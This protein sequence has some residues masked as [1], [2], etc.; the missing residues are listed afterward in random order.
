MNQ[1]L[2]ETKGSSGSTIDLSALFAKAFGK[3]A[4]KGPSEVTVELRVNKSTLGEIKL[5]SNKNGVIDRAETEAL[6]LLLKEALKEH[7]FVRFSDKLA[8]GKKTTFS[9]L[10]ELDI[11]AYYNSTNLSLDLEIPSELRKP[12]VLSMLSKKKASVREENKVKAHEISSFANLYSNVGF[13]SANTS[14]TDLKMKLEGSVNIGGK[15]FE[16][17]VDYRN[18][19]FEL[20]RTKLTYDKPDKLQ[21]FTMGNISTGS[22]NFQENLELDGIRISK[23]FFMDPELQIRPK[24]NEAFV[25]ESDSE[26]EVYINNRLMQRYYLKEGVYALE[27]I[28]LYD[29][30]NNIRVRI[31]DEF[32]KVTVK[33]S[34]QFYDSHLLKPGLSLFA[35]N[36]GYLSNKQ[37]VADTTLAKEPI[38]SGYYQKGLTKD[39]TLSVDA[40]ISPNSYLLGTE[41]ISSI[42]IGSIKTGFAVSGG[43]KKD[44]GFATSFEFKPNRQRETIGLDTLREDMLGLDTSMRG[45]LNS[46]TLSGEYRNENFSL[47]NGGE[48]NLIKLDDNYLLPVPKINK[49]IKSNLQSNFSINLT[50]EWRGFL[51]LGVSDYYDSNENYYANLSAT[52]RFNNGIRLSLGARYDTDDDFSMN[53]QFSVPLSNKRGTRKKDFDLLVDSKN[54]SLKSKLNLRPTS[55]VGKNSLGGSLEHYQDDLSRQQNLDLQYRGANFETN[56][57]A[58]NR[59]SI[60]SGSNS[61]Q[62]NLGFNTSLACV[63][64]SCA[65]SLPI[66]DSF[67]LVSGP[68]NQSNPIAINNSNTRFRYSDGNET[69]LPDNYTALIRDKGKKAV[70]RL[71]SYRFQNINIDESTLPNGYD[72]EKTE[73]EVFPQYHQGFMIKAGGEPATM[74][75]GML[76]DEKKKGLG[77]KGGQW[78]PENGEG[79]TIAF[80]SNK[81]GRFRVTSI[82]SGK[83]NLELFD[84]PDMQPFTITVPDTKGKVHDLGD[85]IVYS[86]E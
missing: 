78:V 81:A 44:T 79:K 48:L 50:E 84:Y 75:D 52:R 69:G 27:E 51:N 2:L 28:G 34:Q 31:K 70:V 7:V 71:E 26:V 60:S 15:V 65:S 4:V 41:I 21:R 86:V 14:N 40:Q 16:T 63:G 53:L 22:R 64:S 35:F 11:S 36:V 24:A 58:R 8:K 77:F 54:N 46:W 9:S 20:G 3:K 19:Q 25:L 13:D 66:D 55:L 17:V 73:F 85:V 82:P 18:E 12:Q 5:F 72:T 62:L 37:V 32:G 83:Y 47:L 67:A 74:L 68:S 61:Q 43:S 38:I 30:A 76:V 59:H 80:F 49:R 29:G 10:D 39:L 57:A 23:E 45:F 33:S 42:S 1:R 56:L 6:L